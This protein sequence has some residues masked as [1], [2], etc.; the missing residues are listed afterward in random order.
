MPAQR[1]SVR[2][3]GIQ[4]AAAQQTRY[5]LPG[6]PGARYST[7]P[8]RR[9]ASSA[10]STVSSLVVETFV[11][12]PVE[13]TLT[14]R[15]AAMT[16]SRLNEHESVGVPECV[17]IAV[18]LPADGFEDRAKHCTPV[19]RVGQQPGPGLGCV[20]E[21]GQIHSHDRPPFIALPRHHVAGP[22]TRTRAGSA[23]WRPGLMLSAIT[24]RRSSARRAPQAGKRPLLVPPRR[25]LVLHACT[26]C[27]ISAPNPRRKRAGR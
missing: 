1:V 3:T 12:A 22:P 6:A 26:G 15:P 19:L 10:S 7:P 11:N 5:E 8:P 24:R 2:E 13:A 25:P 16:S 4:R 18:Q 23:A 20:A 21:L 27:A 17:P 14:R 9:R